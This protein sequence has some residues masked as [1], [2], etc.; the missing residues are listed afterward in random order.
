MLYF[1]HADNN[2]VTSIDSPYLQSSLLGD[3]LRHIA[4]TRPVGEYRMKQVSGYYMNQVSGYY[5]NQFSEYH[6]NQSSECHMTQV[7]IT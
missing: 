3:Q 1:I 6:I 2:E 5:M 4:K 7:S